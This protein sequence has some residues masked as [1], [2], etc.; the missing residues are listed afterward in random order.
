MIER[1]MREENSWRVTLD[2][3]GDVV[4]AAEGVRVTRQPARSGWQRVLD[5]FFGILPIRDQL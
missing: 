4:W 3:D 5:G 1:D 2:E